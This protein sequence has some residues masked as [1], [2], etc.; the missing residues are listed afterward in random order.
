MSE[1]FETQLL[2]IWSSAQTREGCLG[3]EHRTQ[4][5]KYATV[6]DT[7][8]MCGKDG[9]GPGGESSDVGM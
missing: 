8:H 7:Q 3:E 5:C 4:K 6:T 9:R 1:V 2:R